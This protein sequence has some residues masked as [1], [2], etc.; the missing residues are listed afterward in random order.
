MWDKFPNYRNLRKKSCEVPAACPL[1]G[2]AQ[3]TQGH[4]AFLCTH[5]LAQALRQAYLHQLRKITATLLYPPLNRHHREV[6]ATI[7]S[8]RTDDESMHSLGLALGRP[9]PSIIAKLPV[10]GHVRSHHYMQYVKA[11]VDTSLCTLEYLELS[12]RGRNAILGLSDLRRRQLSQ[13]CSFHEVKALVHQYLSHKMPRRNPSTR[14]RLPI[15]AKVGSVFSSQALARFFHVGTVRSPAALAVSSSVGSDIAVM[16]QATV[17]SGDR[18][19]PA[20]LISESS[21]TST[22]LSTPSENND[23]IPTTP[24]TVEG[25]RRNPGRHAR[26]ISGMNLEDASVLYLTGD[27]PG[28]VPNDD[29]AKIL[30]LPEPTHI[31][32]PDGRVDTWIRKSYHCEDGG[33]GLYFYVPKG[34]LRRGTLLDVYVG[35]SNEDTNTSYADAVRRWANSDYVLADRQHEYVINGHLSSGAARANE[36]FGAVNSILYFNPEQ[37]RGELLVAATIR[38]SGYYEALVNYTEPHRPS[39]YWTTRRVSLLPAATRAKCLQFYGSPAIPTAV[40][41]TL[42]S[43]M[44]VPAAKR[45]LPPSMSGV[46]PKKQRATS[47]KVCNSLGSKATKRKRPKAPEGNKPKKP[48]VASSKVGN[49]PKPPIPIPAWARPP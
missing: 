37:R 10:I 36:S 43:S 7:L 1:C 13:H 14:W 20:V 11:L 15:H 25:P 33:M 8:P 2:I 35:E 31:R 34:G 39:P 42:I 27:V 28:R 18:V 23:D 24:P 5:P 6:T 40:Q 41:R 26:P 4:L 46:Q 21:E 22:T 47:P 45:K 32:H 30:D 17:P 12:W 44:S 38:I 29:M 16:S 49:P 9:I 19:E 48:R 3:D